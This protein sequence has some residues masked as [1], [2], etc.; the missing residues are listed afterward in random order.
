MSDNATD[1]KDLGGK[2]TGQ[3]AKAQP[4][5]PKGDNPATSGHHE[6]PPL[7]SATPEN[8]DHRLDPSAPGNTG[9]TPGTDRVA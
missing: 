4:S 8:A 2:Q 3:G 7:V 6:N 9:T 1:T 5:G